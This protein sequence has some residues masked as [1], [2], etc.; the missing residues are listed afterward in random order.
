MIYPKY[1]PKFYHQDRWGSDR[2]WITVRMSAIPEDKQKEVAIQ[3]ERLF[4]SGAD[5]ARKQANEYLHK[6]A[7]RY[8]DEKKTATQKP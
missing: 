7:K 5:D 4:L 2:D 6:T 3:Y 1:H 8:R